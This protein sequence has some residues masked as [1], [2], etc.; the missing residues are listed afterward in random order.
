MGAS[1]LKVAPTSRLAS[2]SRLVNSTFV[3]MAEWKPVIKSVDMKEEMK[4]FAEKTVVDALSTHQVEQLIA[5]HIKECF[6]EAYGPSWHCT[7]GRRFGTYVTHETK[8]YIFL[9]I[10]NVYVLL[11]KCGNQDGN[12]IPL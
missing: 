6:E 12:A 3:I 8:N 4:A 1:A 9:S 11:Y 5:G 2:S 7:V 10:G